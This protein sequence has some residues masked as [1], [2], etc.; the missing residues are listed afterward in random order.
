MTGSTPVRVDTT[1][2]HPARMYDHY[3]GGKD[4]YE[5]DA[6]AAARVLEVFPGMRTCARVNRAFM[7][8]AVRWLAAEAGIR[9]FLDVGTGIPTEPNLHQVAQAV[10]PECRV[11]YA[12]NDP[13]VLVYAQALLKGTAA[14]RT[15]YIQADVRDPAGILGA[16]ELR[17]TLDLGRPVALC[18]G[19]LLHFVRD[20][21]GPYEVVAHLVGALPSGSYLMLSHCTPG[22]APEAWERVGAVYGSGGIRAQVRGRTEVADFFSG[23]ELVEPG[24]TMPHLWKP[25]REPPPGI[26]PADVSM[27][28]GVARKP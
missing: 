8:R 23:L 6:E 13:I 15:S 18:L 2:P 20:E 4:H 3:L 5:A 19:A 16:A 17:G 28:A 1:Q 26:S 9:Q 10:A 12:D 21:D 25:D 27:Y 14:G 7:H 24:V 22:F 11:V